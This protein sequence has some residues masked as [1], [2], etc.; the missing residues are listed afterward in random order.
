MADDGCSGL[1]DFITDDELFNEVTLNEVSD[2]QTGRPTKRRRL[3]SHEIDTDSTGRREIEEAGT[4][5]D[6]FD[7]SLPPNSKTTGKGR[8]SNDD[9]PAA[10]KPKTYTPKYHVDQKPLFVTQTQ[11]SSSPSRIRGPRWKAPER[12]KPSTASK[13]KQKSPLPAIWGRKPSTIG[14]HGTNGKD[15]DAAIAASLRSFEEEQSARG[16]AEMLGDSIEEPGDTQVHAPPEKETIFDF[17]D[18]PDDA[19]DFEPEFTETADKE[20]ILIS[21]QPRPSQNT[22]RRPTA[23][24]ST[25]FRQTTLLGGF[26]SS[27][28]KRSSQP[29]TQTWPS[30][31]RNEPPTHHELNKDALRTWIFPKNLGSRR[32]YQFNIA[33][34]ALFH[35]LLVAL[36]TG[37]GKTFI[38][39]TV[40]L[41]W[42]HWTKDAQIVFV[43]P[44]KPLVSQQVDAC[45]HI[46]G[47]PRSQTTLLTG[48]TPPGVRAE[49]WRSKRVFFMTPQTI[50]NDLK[51]GIADPKRIVLLV[52]DEAHRATGAY[53]YVEIVKFLQR[54]NNSFRVLALTATPGATVEAVQ[55]VIDG[56]SIS[57]IEIRT[58]KSLDIRGFVHQRNVETITFE[59]S[60]D[61]ITSMELFA[62]AL[63]PVVDRLRNQNAYWGRDPMALTPFGLTKARQEWNSSPAGRAASWPVKGTINSMF[64]VLASLAHAIDL[65]KY[66][67]IGPFYR[68]LVSFEDSVLKEKKGGK[69]ASQIVADGNFK[70][71]MSKLR[72]W[73]NTEEFIGHPKL[74][75]LRRAILNHFLDA[76]GKN[77]GDSEGSDSNTRVM[78]FSHFRDSAEEIVRVL[79]KHQPFVRPH[80][81]IGQANAK[82][83]EGM[84]Q[85][86]QLEVVGKF[87]TGT[88]NTIVATSIGEEGLDIGEVDLIICYDGHSSPIRM[89]QRMGRTG[90]KRA[91]N[92]ILLLSKGKEEESYSKAKDNYEKMQQ[93]IA[94]GSRFTFHT[95]K[96]SRIVPQDIQPEAEEK[97][98]EIPI[99]NS[100]LGLPEPAK[101]S[102]A[103]KRPPK[104]FHMPDGVEKGFTKASR[105][106]RTN[107]DSN[108]H[109]KR[110]RVVRTP[111][112]EL[113]EFPDLGD[114]CANQSQELADDPDFQEVAGKQISRLRMD[115]YPEHQRSLRPTGFIEHGKYTRR[116][117]KTFRKIS[118]LGFDCEAQYRAIV[119]DPDDD[120]EGLEGLSTDRE[121][122][123]Q[124]ITAHQSREQPPRVEKRCGTEELSSLDIEA[125]FPNLT[126]PAR[127]E[128]PR[129]E[130]DG[131]D[132]GNQKPSQRK[133]RYMISDDSDVSE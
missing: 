47:I 60:R 95:D 78:I 41:N 22:T 109:R 59:N 88:Y 18:I 91:G 54:F 121:D 76:G 58:E 130:S 101:R 53:A 2:S 61:M 48:N 51:T 34:R 31:S 46:A 79:R 74:E 63:Q 92:I 125:F 21:S 16:D 94:S 55:E 118:K 66:H 52:V 116:V 40:M 10:R 13:A 80:V 56:L 73:T 86:T 100:Q 57:R 97:M 62:K 104:K 123:P 87:K 75:Y 64:T 102:R 9:N 132:N 39:A 77:D 32:E 107:T 99:E 37:L 42:F 119:G 49:E 26:A 68:N 131:T 113:E 122:D 129:P 117:V 7:P 45:F 23:S 85:K 127:P 93:L 44:T 28:S 128:A 111:S 11:P 82:G 133:K 70:V 4:D 38:A 6:T 5:S 43:A 27:S 126:W 50:V 81:F 69:C 110:K 83:S 115:V 8:K 35:N 98:I 24:Q 30:S 36:P 25:S 90:R 96:S 120:G 17:E 106:G 20:P 124:S 89:L 14:S 84:D 3:N 103:P 1:S 12:N 108:G 112:P 15:I 67:G 105:L 19:F 29:A 71:L 33:H 72:S 65:L 114:L